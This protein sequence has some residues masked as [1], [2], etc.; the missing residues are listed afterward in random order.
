MRAFYENSFK[1]LCRSKSSLSLLFLSPR[2]HYMHLP[3]LGAH[4]FPMRYAGPLSTAPVGRGFCESLWPSW[5]WGDL[6]KQRFRH[7]ARFPS[8]LMEYVVPALESPFSDSFRVPRLPRGLYPPHWASCLCFVKFLRYIS[9]SNLVKRKSNYYR[10]YRKKTW[11]SH[12]LQQRTP[13]SKPPPIPGH[14]F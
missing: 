7:N 3:S 6:S 12:L 9:R 8:H 1:V 5:N 14:I 13:K 4:S 10:N 2:I 11:F